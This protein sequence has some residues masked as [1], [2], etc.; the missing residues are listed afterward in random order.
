MHIGL[1]FPK[2]TFLIDPM[3]YP[4]LG[5]WYLAAQ[6]EAQGHTTEFMDLSVDPFPQDGDFDQVWISATSP[7]MHE[8]R[9]LAAW[10]CDWLRTRTVF[11][12]AAPWANPDSAAE[13]PF[14]T[15]VSGEADHPDMVREIVP[16]LGAHLKPAIPRGEVAGGRPPVRR[17]DHKYHTTLE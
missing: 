12:G 17:W 11:G 7:Q 6:L 2:S 5:L 8:V 14:S 16:S 9:R 1:V 15:I 3:V 10:T 4:P 13:L